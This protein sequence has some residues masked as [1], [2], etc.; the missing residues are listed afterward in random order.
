[1]AEPGW[2]AGGPAVIASHK[3]YLRNLARKKALEREA[4]ALR[5]AAGG[6]QHTE[7]LE[8]GFQGYFNGANRDVGPGK[9][10]ER[11][12]P[13][14]TPTPP[15]PSV[16]QPSQA[17]RRRSTATAPAGHRG[18][19]R[20]T[21]GGG[22][23]SADDGAAADAPPTASTRRQWATGKIFGFKITEGEDKGEVVQYDVRLPVRGDTPGVL[24]RLVPLVDRTKI[25]I[26]RA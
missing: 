9:K 26:T 21:H 24:A 20:D 6:K 7:Q 11:P 10:Q 12:P 1:M 15:T 13:R 5:A 17:P 23:S 4:T 2:R 16:P 25:P 14:D 8:K 19:K 22:D 18:L 3:E